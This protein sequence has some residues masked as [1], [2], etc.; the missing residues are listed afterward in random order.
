MTEHPSL[1]LVLFWQFWYQCLNFFCTSPC[2]SAV[3][4]VNIAYYV[5]PC[6]A[7]ECVSSRHARHAACC[8]LDNEEMGSWTRDPLCQPTEC[9]P[10]RLTAITK[11]LYLTLVSHLGWLSRAVRLGGLGPIRTSPCLETSV[12][13]F[14]RTILSFLLFFIIYCV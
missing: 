10:G 14:T 3:K 9:W 11:Y 2:C 13:Y 8:L 1:S 12:R 7:K 4:E 6:R 5:L